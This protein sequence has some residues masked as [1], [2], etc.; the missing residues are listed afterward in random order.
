MMSDRNVVIRA[1]IVALALLVLGSAALSAQG[2]TLAIAA[3]EGGATV[4]AP[5]TIEWSAEGVTIK[6]AT[7]ATSREEGHFHV[8]VDKSPE[9][10]EGVPIPGG[11]P[12]IIHTAATSLELADLADGE[13]TV[14]VVLGYSDHTPWW[15]QVSDSVTF[16]VGAMTEGASEPAPETMPTTGTAS[17]DPIYAL[18]VAVGALL[19]GLALLVRRH[20]A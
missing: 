4:A 1:L 6:G 20:P 19:L 17:R 12:Q 16:T 5:V 13:H 11:D 14:T 7:D 2:P 10:E 18:I 9:L 8:F 3:P 15:P